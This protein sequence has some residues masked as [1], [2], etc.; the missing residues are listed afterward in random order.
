MSDPVLDGPPAIRFGA[1]ELDT[2]TGELRKHGVRLTLQGQPFQVLTLLLERPGELVSREQLRQRLWPSGTFVDFEQ[3]LNAAVKRLRYVLGDSSGTPRFVETLPR[4]GYRFIALVE[5]CGPAAADS[6]APL[7][8]RTGGLVEGW[9]PGLATRRSGTTG[10]AWSA[11]GAFVLAA[12]MASWF[13]GWRASSRSAEMRLLPLTSLIG[14]ESDPAVSPDGGHVAFVWDGGTSGGLSDVYVKVVGSEQVIKVADG[15]GDARTPAW[16]PDGRE[17][18]LVRPGGTGADREVVIVS[19]LGGPPRRVATTA[20]RLPGLSWTPDG[21]QLAMV[22]REAQ[23]DP[24]GIFLLSLAD[25]SKRRLTLATSTDDGDSDPHFSPDGKSLAFIRR[26]QA[27]QTA[28]LYV[29]RVATSAVERMTYD[30]TNIWGADWTADGQR[31]V[32]SSTRAGSNGRF[33]LWAIP[34]SGGAPQRLDLAADAILPSVSRRGG[35]LVY[36]KWEYDLN[37]WRV[38]GPLSSGE[39]RAAI[40]FITSTAWEWAPTYSPDGRKVAFTSLRTGTNEIWVAD[41]DGSGSQQVTSLGSPRTSM[42]SWSPDSRRLAFSSNVKGPYEIFTVPATGGFA[43]RMTTDPLDKTLVSWSADARWIYYTARDRGSSQIWKLPSAGG[44]PIQVTREGAAEGHENGDGSA[45]FFVKRRNGQGPPGIWR[46]H[47]AGGH[48]QKVVDQGEARRWGVFA[49]GVCYAAR[50]ATPN[51]E[52]L[53]AKTG[54]AVSIAVAKSP[55]ALGVTVSPDGRWILYVQADK[56]ERD[57]RTIEG[58][59]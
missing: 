41:A 30:R 38:G 49:Q 28:E 19:A 33:C 24:D 3:G 27:F 32:F 2:R 57:L 18:A 29:L 23:A 10:R 56:D 37:I 55:A 11:V 59:I 22:D 34:A 43:E 50:G 1:F 14:S 4:R 36:V 20:G 5:G 45:L 15:H 44:E 16:S 25:G 7:D 54:R 42:T 46:M 47:P 13:V 12:I 48:Q 26:P 8:G 52:C 53:D 31:L 35:R 9:P 58:F 21:T 6:S 40:P 39:G 51:I 17:I